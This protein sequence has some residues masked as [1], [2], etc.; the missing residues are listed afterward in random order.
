MKRNIIYSLIVV[1]FL[2]SCLAGC[3]GDAASAIVGKWSQDNVMLEFFKDGS[4][5]LTEDN[6]EYK[7]TWAI[8]NQRLKIKAENEYVSSFDYKITRSALTLNDE[9]FIRKK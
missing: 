1:L 9:K 6:V 3:T 2:T 5:I 8:E 4:G 7:F